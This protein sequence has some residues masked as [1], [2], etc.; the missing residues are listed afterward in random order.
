MTISNRPR[1]SVCLRPASHCLCCLIPTLHSAVNVLV[2][3]HPQEQRHALNTW[4]LLVAGLANSEL[5]VIEQIPTDSTLQMQLADPDWRTELL[6]PGASAQTLSTAPEGDDRPRRLVL[7]DG[8]WRKARKLLLFNPVLQQLPRVALPAGMI[9]RYRLRKASEANA[10]STI[11]AGV[12]ALQL[13]EPGSDYGALLRPFEALS[14][15]RSRPW[16]P[17]AMRAIM[18][19]TAQSVVR[20]GTRGAERAFQ[21]LPDKAQRPGRY[22]QNL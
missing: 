14:K 19:G 20:S 22:S 13:M 10:L 18:N 16:A 4:R 5:V 1:C 6:F 9:S 2:I 17:S 15:A 3:Q 21:C 8:T 7:L 12:Q 11:E